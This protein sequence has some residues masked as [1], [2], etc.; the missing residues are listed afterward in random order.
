M[1]DPSWKL[2]V[3]IIT[4]DWFSRVWVIQEISVARKHLYLCGS[5]EINPDD[6]RTLAISLGSLAV[7][8]DTMLLN[9]PK[10]IVGHISSFQASIISF[11]AADYAENGP[12]DFLQLLYLTGSLE[13]TDSRD[14]LFA[15]IGIS[16]DGP[17]EMI[18][19]SRD[20]RKLLIDVGKM[21]LERKTSSEV[22]ALDILSFV[23]HS[24]QDPG[25]PSWVPTWNSI[26]HSRVPLNFIMQPKDWIEAG[27]ATYSFSGERFI[28]R[29]RILDQIDT[30][31]EA[32]PLSQPVSG[33]VAEMNK[34]RL[35]WDRE[36]SELV[37]N[38]KTYPTGMLLDEAHWRALCFNG[39][40]AN[41]AAPVEWGYSYG[42]WTHMLKVMPL[43]E[44][45]HPIIHQPGFEE[46]AR[47]FNNTA[48]IFEIAISTNPGGR[49][50]CITEKGYIGWI[51]LVAR[52]G[53][54]VG[55][56]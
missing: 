4:R 10:T 44:A 9:L 7:I 54:L 13:A 20:L 31:V 16:K 6:V 19:Y 32:T 34:Q 52:K 24:T 26:N 29:G 39:G 35:I 17:M 42:A 1:D 40:C 48:R 23:N 33:T 50:F 53:D 45:G 30:V 12:L 55:L 14:K 38:L 25:I 56:T 51:S 36:V 37:R 22:P 43:V 49:R 5:L 11:I 8:R 41:E 28:V 21:F 27:V 3:K 18:D 47:N 15:L 46:R 2:V